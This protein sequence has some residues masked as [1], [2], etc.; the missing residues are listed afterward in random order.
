MNNLL[1]TFIVTSLLL[2][3]LTTSP[4]VEASNTAEAICEYVAS[5][6]KKR[7]RSF[8]KQNNLKIRRIFK[9]LQCNGKN[10]LAFAV[11]SDAVET[12]TLII[13]KLPKK[14]V[15]ENLDVINTGQ[16]ALIDAATE[17]LSG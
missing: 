1:I 6:D 11:V 17:R 2:L 3:S 5:D 9:S 8:L 10:L 7:L 16:K 14:V 15:T 4:K 12:G 13:H